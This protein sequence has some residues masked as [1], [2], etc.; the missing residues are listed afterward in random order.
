MKKKLLSSLLGVFA[1]LTVLISVDSVSAQQ[2]GWGD[3][4][5]W[6]R[7]YNRVNIDQAIKRVEDRSD[8][9]AEQLDR[10]LD[11]TNTDGTAREDRIE[12][13]AEN[14]ENATDELRRE[15]D[16]RGD[17]WWETRENVTKTMNAAREL[18]RLMRDRRLNRL[19]GNTWTLLQR[20]LNALARYY[21]LPRV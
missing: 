6:A 5:G 3:R 21:N 10:A 1:L 17:S 12:R 18:N 13:A 16:R 20:D 19:T 7:R 4:P 11:R 8:R 2:R 14:L 15:F 9:F